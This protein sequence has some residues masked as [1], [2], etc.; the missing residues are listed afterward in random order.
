MIEHVTPPTPQN[1]TPADLISVSPEE[2]ARITGVCR[3]VIY[4]A[5]ARG[6]I[7]GFKVGR[8]RLFLVKDL[9]RWMQKMAKEHRK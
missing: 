4:Q 5:Q 9:E 3:S 2:A 1:P 6:E 8:R 7:K